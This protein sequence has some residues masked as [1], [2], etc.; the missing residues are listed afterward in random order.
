MMLKNITKRKVTKSMEVKKETTQNLTRI[1]KNLM[2]SSE[3][4]KVMIQNLTKITKRLKK[5][6]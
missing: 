3:V 6:W 2:K 5:V 4:K 1:M